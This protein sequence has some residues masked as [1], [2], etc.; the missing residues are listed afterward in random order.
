MAERDKEMAEEILS[1]FFSVERGASSVKRGD[2]FDLRTLYALTLYAART[3]SSIVPPGSGTPG[4]ETGNHNVSC[5]ATS[6]V[7]GRDRA[8]V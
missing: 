5:A 7:D 8:D 1:Y 3:A 6:Q 2:A 4:R